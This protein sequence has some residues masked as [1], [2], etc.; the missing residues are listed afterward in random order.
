MLQSIGTMA[1]VSFLACSSI[2]MGANERLFPKDLPESRW[3]EFSAMGLPQ[4][5]SGIIYNTANHPCC[6]MPLGSVDTGCLDLDVRGV[7]GF[8]CIFNPESPFPFKSGWRMPR[9]LP[10]PEPLLG[11]SIGGK[12]YIMT[13]ADFISGKEVPWCTE[14][15]LFGRW[16]EFPYKQHQV[17]TCKINNVVPVRDIRY[18]GHYPAVDME[19]E[20]D[21][22][23][24]VG[25]RA[26]SPFLPGDTAASNTPAA[27]FEVHLRNTT[28][29]P[30]KGCQIGRAHV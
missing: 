14:P 5:V 20:T 18:W 24:S 9:K 7:Y 21:A 3:V 30:Q 4:P 28:D 17:P 8:S 27:V 15:Y 19:F 23:V 11:L 25:M 2:V 10:R 29:Q 12:T 16:S 1:F 22:P 26:W 6:G 13:T